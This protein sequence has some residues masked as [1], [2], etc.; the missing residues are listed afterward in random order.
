MSQRWIRKCCSPVVDGVDGVDSLLHPLQAVINAGCFFPYIAQRDAVVPM[1][2]QG[3]EKTRGY[4]EVG[5]LA[6]T[7]YMTPKGYEIKQAAY[8]ARLYSL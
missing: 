4:Q 2:E 3:T 6:R 5:G 7:Y 8:K 1:R